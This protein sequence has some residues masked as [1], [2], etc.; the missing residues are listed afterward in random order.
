MSEGDSHSCETDVGCDVANGVH[1]SGTED[2]AE[3]LLVDG[4]REKKSQQGMPC[5][6]LGAWFR[7]VARH[8]TVCGARAA[9]ELADQLRNVKLLSCQVTN[10]SEAH[11]AGHAMLPLKTARLGLCL[12]CQRTT[13]SG[14]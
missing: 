13:S 14:P 1:E 12:P 4:L 9:D 11:C 5:E 10:S 2:G 8:Q 6:Q 7:K 3:L